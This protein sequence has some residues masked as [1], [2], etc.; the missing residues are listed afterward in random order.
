MGRKKKNDEPIFK[1][2]MSPPNADGTRGV[3]PLA[4]AAESLRKAIDNPPTTLAVDMTLRGHGIEIP[5]AIQSQYIPPPLANYG[6]D[7]EPRQC[8][9]CG[10]KNTRVHKTRTVGRL[11]VRYRTC[12]KCGRNFM[13]RE[14]AP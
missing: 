3:S 9:H 7:E 12:Q 4:G 8:I 6:A 2:L 10:S 11:T 14:I 5:S 13:T 1:P